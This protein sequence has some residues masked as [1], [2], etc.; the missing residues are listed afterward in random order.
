MSTCILVRKTKHIKSRFFFIM[1]KIN[2]GEVDVEYCSAQK[3][4]CDALNTHNQGTPY[5]TDRSHLMNVP[6]D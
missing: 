1:E 2:Q 4:W 6:V 3:M 5:R